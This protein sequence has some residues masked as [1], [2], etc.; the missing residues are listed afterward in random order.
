MS[1][2]R[3]VSI[4]ALISALLSVGAIEEATAQSRTTSAIR[5]RVT[6]EDGTDVPDA[7]V[8]IRHA[9]TGAEKNTVTNADGRYVISLLQPGGPYTLIVQHLGFAEVTRE[10]IYLQVGE[11]HTQN[12]M[13][14][15]QALEVEGVTVA[16][17]RT[18][19]FDA[20]QVGHA[21][22]LDEVQLEALPIISRDLMDLAIL[23]PL[24]KT[25]NNGGFSVLGQNDRYNA[26]LV[27]GVSNK[28]AFG[29]TAGGVP[30]GQ[31]GARIIPFDAVS[32]YEVLVAPFDVR[33]SGFTGGVLN[34]VT[35]TGTNEWRTRASIVHRNE[36]LT[37]DLNLPTGPV[38]AS[39][40]DRSL[41]AFSVGGPIARDRAHFFVA[42]E[43][44]QKS[45]P[46]TG[47]NLERDPSALIRISPE[48]LSAFQDIFD[49]QFGLTTGIGGPFPLDTQLANLFSRVDWNFSGGD[50][51]T[52]RNVFALAETDESPNR[53]QFEPYELSSNGVL[54]ESVNNSAS[55]QLF[56]D[57]GTTGGNE[58]TLNVQHT[59]DKTTP[60]SDWPQVGID[61]ISP[62][63]GAAFQREVRVGSQ[64]FAQE[65]NLEQTNLRITNSLTIVNDSSTFTLGATAAYYDFDH[66][67][68]PGARGDWFFPS[69]DDVI[70]NTPE[71]FQRQ[72]LLDGQDPSARF[73]VLE[74]GLFFQNQID[75]IEGVTLRIGARIDVP[76]VL[77]RPEE[78]P[79]VMDL[80]GIN[81]AS[82]P[83]GQILFSPRLGF[84]VQRG[85]RLRTQIRGG[86]GLFAGQIPFVWLSNAF[87]NNGLT[88][89][90]QLCQGRS[91]LEPLPP[92]AVPGFDPYNPPTSCFN[93]APFIEQRTVAAFDEEFRYPQELR[94][95]SV[96]D[97]ELT[98]T[99]T[100]SVGFM[101]TH[102][103]YQV[104]LRDLNLGSPDPD[105]GPM[106]GYGGF[107]RRLFGSPTDEGFE[108]NRDH[109]QYDHVLV[110]GNES[111]DWAFTLTSELRGSL[112]DSRVRYQVGYTFGR[113][114]DRMS[115]TFT[116]ML[117]NYGFNP[118]SK[119][120]NTASLRTSNFDIPHKIVASAFGTP[121]PG[122]PDTEISLLYTGQSGIP[123]SYV[124]RGDLNGDGFPGL[125]GAFDRTND[126]VYVPEDATEVPSGFATTS[127]LNNA[128][129]S[130]SCLSANR[131]KILGRNACRA[132][133]Q[134]RLDLRIAHTLRAGGA[135]IRFEADV[136]NVLNLLNKNWGNIETVRPTISLLEPV[137]RGSPNPALYGSRV[138][139]LISQWAGAVLPSTDE[140]GRLNATQPWSILSPDSQWQ[141]QFGI[142]VTLD[143]NR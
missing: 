43:F 57:F 54:R 70:T 53:S 61:L 28:D 85:D 15:P 13:V 6:Q 117:S 5:G 78:N 138:G 137:V 106:D 3:S 121:I 4:A 110:A 19:I 51:L 45:Q 127:I 132:P 119:D 124:Y 112:Y 34:A 79:E 60:T 25:T 82:V 32:Q 107:D 113:S 92:R 122:L 103:I 16:I 73:S 83:S 98:E 125:G 2:I 133:W 96:I 42:G 80:F 33:L 109:P 48:S 37:G 18:D 123:F 67:F 14:Q 120:P 72:V 30:G 136:I 131:G 139:P 128:L 55:V 76:H 91:N 142:R 47:F 56:S 65:N 26:I 89:V 86:I 105:P 69:P 108:A 102:A 101:F 11:R 7:N 22:R 44:E 95:S 1:G 88:S 58:L 17:E 38:D 115:L 40:V 100:A 134:N 27:D 135:D 75:A 36:N 118:T 114:F 64:F 141:A 8:T 71:R 23:S 126:L 99:M 46:P 81:T 77:D 29:L 20:G 62:V 49:G 9:E 59:R 129:E 97:R 140:E 50:R 90:T 63:A 87:H 21:T 74:W 39:G 52:I 12:V 94:F 31:A 143:R 68:L 66:R 93:G 116:D 10:G 84:N 130:D 24:V 41:Y 35:R 104:V 111:R